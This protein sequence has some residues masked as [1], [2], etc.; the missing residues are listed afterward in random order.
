LAAQLLIFFLHIGVIGI[1]GF[2]HSSFLSG[3]L[4]YIISEKH[5]AWIKNGQKNSQRSKSVLPWSIAV[6]LILGLLLNY[7]GINP[8]QALSYY[9]SLVW[10]RHHR[11]SLQLYS[12]YSNNKKNHG[13][14]HK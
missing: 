11:A 4:A 13:E 10:H 9:G 8:I 12:I 3:S 1:S 14:I 2:S 7:M 6:S 5:L